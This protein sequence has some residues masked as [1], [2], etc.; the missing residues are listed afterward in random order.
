MA[1]HILFWIINGELKK[2]EVGRNV[3]FSIQLLFSPIKKT[4]NVGT[5]DIQMYAEE[6]SEMKIICGKRKFT[7]L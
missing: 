2:C 4:K 1:H 5:A 6:G 7:V 3:P